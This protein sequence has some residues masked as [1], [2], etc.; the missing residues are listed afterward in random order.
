M[1]PFNLNAIENN[2]DINNN[3][4]MRSRHAINSD[5]KRRMKA[6]LIARSNSRSNNLK[7]SI[8]E[9]KLA[10]FTNMVYNKE[11]QLNFKD[12]PSKDFVSQSQMEI[13]ALRVM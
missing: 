4:T 2:E 8:I 5:R 1:T 10:D 12:T 6:N 13:G 9:N 11:I 7:A 3:D